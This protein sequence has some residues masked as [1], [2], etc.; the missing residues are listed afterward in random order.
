MIVDSALLGRKVTRDFRLREYAC[1]C[2]CGLAHPHPAL[3]MAVQEIRDWLGVPVTITSGCRCYKHNIDSGGAALS[4]H[5]PRSD[6][7]GYCC[8]ADLQA[9]VPLAIIGMAAEGV[10]AVESGGCAPYIS[11]DS[12]W[13]HIDVR[14]VTGRH[15]PWVLGYIDGNAAKPE[16]VLVKDE[17]RRAQRET[18][19]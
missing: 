16:D 4:Y 12:A 10:E 15:R 14:G 11:G 5:T 19:S 9:D 8:A 6:M 1:K 3:A 13:L 2:G 18:A 17:L 7:A